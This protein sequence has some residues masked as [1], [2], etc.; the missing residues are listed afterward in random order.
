MRSQNR[1]PERF[2][3]TFNRFLVWTG[4]YEYDLSDAELSEARQAAWIVRET[5]KVLVKAGSPLAFT[6]VIL[7]SPEPCGY[8]RSRQWLLIHSTQHRSRACFECW[9]D[10]FLRA[11]DNL[12]QGERTD[13]DEE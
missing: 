6:P 12:E 10:A 11:T 8:C 9:R 2:R 7:S 3:N 4:R 1:I 5:S 13:A